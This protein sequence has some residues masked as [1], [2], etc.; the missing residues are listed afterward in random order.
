[1]GR[2][3]VETEERGN[4]TLPVLY[5]EHSIHYCLSDLLDCSDLEDMQLALQ[6]PLCNRN[7]VGRFA[8]GTEERGNDILH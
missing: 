1:M 8:V 3:A 4:S 2:F 6:Y 7:F 5:T